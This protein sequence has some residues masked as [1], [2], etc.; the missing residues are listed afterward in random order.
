MSISFCF[1]IDVKVENETVWLSQQQ[2]AELF[3]TS[4]TNIIEHINNIYSEEELDKNSTCQNFRQVQKEGNRNVTREIHFYNLD[5]IISLGYRIKSKIATNFRRWATERLKEYMIKGLTMDDERLKGNGG[6]L[7]KLEFFKG[8][9]KIIN[10]S[11]RYFPD[12]YHIVLHIFK[13]LYF[14]SKKE[15]KAI[16]L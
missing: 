12:L 1:F 6:G 2:M 3:K 15:E 8:S 11:S 9:I 7:R 10:G 13:Y 14:S 16:V 4:R 5:M